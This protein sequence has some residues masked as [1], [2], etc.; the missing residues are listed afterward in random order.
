MQGVTQ[1]LNVNN[2][3]LLWSGILNVTLQSCRT[4]YTRVVMNHFYTILTSEISYENQRKF[5]VKNLL[6]ISK[7]QFKI[8]NKHKLQNKHLKFL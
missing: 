2:Q 6:K 5:Q 4:N 7:L 1:I 8:K 3:A